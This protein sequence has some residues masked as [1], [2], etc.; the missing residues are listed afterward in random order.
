VRRRAARLRRLLAQ[1]SF[2]IRHDRAPKGERR[3]DQALRAAR[4]LERRMQRRRTS[5][6][7]GA[8][9]VESTIRQIADIRA[10]IE[11]CRMAAYTPS[12]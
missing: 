9:L 11:V 6:R 8:A 1:A 7:A 10:S 5:R 2:E 3:L 12:E 4:K